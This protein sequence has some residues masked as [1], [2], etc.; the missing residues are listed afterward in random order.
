M[1]PNDIQTVFDSSKVRKAR[2]KH[3]ISTYEEPLL[4]NQIQNTK[5]YL[6]DKNNLQ[7]NDY[8]Y[9]DFPENV[10][11]KSFD[12]Q[13]TSNSSHKLH[14]FYKTVQIGKH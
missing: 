5:K 1:K 7:I 2:L 12:V 13:V 6:K 3:H 9:L 4:N 14:F 11:G 8:V 10:F